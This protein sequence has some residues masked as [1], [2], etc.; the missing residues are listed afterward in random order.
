S[1]V[2]EK[3]SETPA[4]A[5]LAEV[6]EGHFPAEN[7]SELRRLLELG[8]QIINNF[9]SHDGRTE[10]LAVFAARL[11]G[12]PHAFDAKAKDGVFLH[13][14]VHWMLENQGILA[15]QT[16]LFPALLKKREYLAV[17]IL[18]DDISNYAM[19]SGVRAKRKNGQPHA[20]MEGFFAE[21]DMLHVPLSVLVGWECA[22]CPDNEIYIMEN[23]S[24]YAL[25]AGRWKGEKAAMCMNGQPRLSSIL[26]LDLLAKTDTK[27]FYA[28]DFDPEGLLIAQKLKQ[29]YPGEFSFWHMSVAEYSRSVSKQEIS[30]KRLKMLEKI[31]DRALLCLADE[32]GRQKRAGYQENIWKEFTSTVI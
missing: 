21:G 29:Y 14:L 22:K 7:L 11:T 10:Y 32:I 13:Q 19:L 17:G 27:I 2:A 15:G 12:N 28:G 26:M 1:D 6:Q 30:A 31:T 20:G 3:Y 25:F 23:P 18:L 16:D 8:A 5:W 9:P 24:V 4:K